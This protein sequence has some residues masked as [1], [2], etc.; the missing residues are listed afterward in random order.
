MSVILQT[1]PLR[2][3]AQWPGADPFLFIA[4]HEDAYPAGDADQAPVADLAGREIGADFAGKDG[5]NMYHGDRVPGFPQHPHRGFETV[6]IVLEGLV[7]HTDS[8]GATARYGEGDTQ[9]LTA[10]AGIAHS[11]MFPLVH[12]DRANPLHLFQIWVNLAPEDK[13]AQPHFAMLWAPDTPVVERVDEH[14]RRSRIRVVAG[15]LDGH[16]PP[17]PP[18]ASWA[19]RPDS[20]VAIWVIDLEPGATLTLPAAKPSI[21]RALYVY[22]GTVSVD[23]TPLADTLAM[24][25]PLAEPTLI[26]G[27]APVRILLLQARPIGAP[28]VQHGPFIATTKDELVQAFVDYQA[29]RFGQWT[30]PANDPVHPADRGRFARY[31]DGT[32]TTPT[33]GGP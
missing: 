29:G 21:T 11:E 32:V 15:E 22:D 25:S 7:D 28:V 2:G 13:T 14:G 10:G 4:H 26:A 31:P 19:S 30:L 23:D 5:W 18:P 1:V 27:S 24:V 6:T 8:V 16:T 33:P 20:D 9:W 12:R 3:A 17:A